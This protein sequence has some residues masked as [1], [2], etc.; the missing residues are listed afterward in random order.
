MWLYNTRHEI[1]V[2][3]WNEGD[4]IEGDDG[5]V[6]RV[7]GTDVDLKILLIK[8]GNLFIWSETG[9][10]VTDGLIFQVSK[11]ELQDKTFE[12]IDGSTHIVYSGNLYRVQ[13]TLDYST[14]K[15]TQLIQCKAM[16]VPNVD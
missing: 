12:I 10:F 8:A 5:L 14:Y 7:K 1:H 9:R 13:S 11:K 3:A 16:K 6:L 15:R 4:P 2:T